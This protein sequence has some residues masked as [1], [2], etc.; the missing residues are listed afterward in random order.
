VRASLGFTYAMLGGSTLYFAYDARATYRLR[1]WRKLGVGLS[2]AGVYRD[3]RQQDFM[4][5]TGHTHTVQAELS[6]G[7]TPEPVSVSVGYSVVRDQLGPPASGMERDDYR[8]TAHGPTL[9]LLARPH[10]LV[11]ILLIGALLHRRFEVKPVEDGAA[12]PTALRQD[13]ALSADL[14]VSVECTSWLEAFAG[15]ALLYNHSNDAAFAF[16]KPMAYLGASASFSAF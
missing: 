9:R 11:D 5:F 6:Y 16:I 13:T 8:A 1:V 15:G 4:V 7:T 2:Y 10:R 3:Y 14:S 12:D